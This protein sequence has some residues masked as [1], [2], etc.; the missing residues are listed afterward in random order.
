MFYFVFATAAVLAIDTS[1]DKSHL[2]V[3]LVYLDETSHKSAPGP[4]LACFL[5]I[6][7]H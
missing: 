6:Y 7:Q 4:N 5:Q 3:K 2:H 1:K